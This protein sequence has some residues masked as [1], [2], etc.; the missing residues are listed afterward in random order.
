MAA[1]PST[2]PAREGVLM[3]GGAAVQA[4]KRTALLRAQ[5][6]WRRGKGAGGAR[7]ARADRRTG[8]TGAESDGGRART[9]DARADS[10]PRR[11]RGRDRSRS[12]PLRSA[13]SS[14]SCAVAGDGTGGWD[15]RRGGERHEGDSQL[16]GSAAECG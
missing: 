9:R 7:G 3:E 2:A 8:A 11:R 6:C 10:D 12:R 15:R 14:I 4:G 16:L 13:D 1:G 5:A